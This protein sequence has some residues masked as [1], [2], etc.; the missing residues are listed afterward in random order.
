MA[1]LIFTVHPVNVE[2]VAWIA[3]RKNLMAML[4]FLLSILSYLK[5]EIPSPSAQNGLYRVRL[6]HGHRVSGRSPLVPLHLVLAEPGGIPVGY[7]QQRIGGVL[8][9]AAA[10]DRLVA[11]PFDKAGHGA[12]R[13]VFRDRRGAG[14]SE[15]VVSNARHWRS[16]P[17]RRFFQRLLGAGGVVWFYLYKAFLPVNLVFIY[18]TWHIDPGD[19]RWWL[20]LI[21]SM[22]VTAVLWRYRK[23][24][25][26]PYLFAWGF[27][28]VA[29]APVMGLTDV[30]FMRYT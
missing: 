12:D 25:S 17:D 4:F 7:A 1:A 2:S 24:W 21:A 15:C 27:F 11:A 10:G 29:L 6:A 3:Q 28:C 22:A 16:D 19:L 14:G 23:A 13:A 26:R 30:Y 5:L 8:A 9:G 20:P 18:P